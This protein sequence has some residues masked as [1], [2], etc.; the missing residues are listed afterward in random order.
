MKQIP[1]FNVDTYKIK[2]SLIPKKVDVTIIEEQDDNGNMRKIRSIAIYSYGF[3]SELTFYDDKTGYRHRDKFPAFYQ[4][5]S[6]NKSNELI[7]MSYY[8]FDELHRDDGPAMI[9]YLVDASKYKSHKKFFE[10]WMRRNQFHRNDGPSYINYLYDPSIHHKQYRFEINGEDI[11]DQVETWMEEC[12]IPP[13]NEWGK[14]ERML[15][16]LI[17]R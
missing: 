6:Y 15:F 9:G 1:G 11:T 5:Q 3:I 17:F 14:S 16:S 13:Y 10:R 8:Q 12:H 2:Y 7:Q 4:F